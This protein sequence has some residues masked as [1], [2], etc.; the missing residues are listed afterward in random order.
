MA[1]R[2][3]ACRKRHA[4]TR[5]CGGCVTMARGAPGTAAAASPRAAARGALLPVPKVRFPPRSRPAGGGA[6]ARAGGADGGAQTVPHTTLQIKPHTAQ[7]PSGR[8][9]KSSAPWCATLGRSAGGRT[10]PFP[11]RK[12]PWRPRMGCGRRTN[13][14]FHRSFPVAQHERSFHTSKKPKKRVTCVTERKRS[15][16]PCRAR[17]AAMAPFRAASGRAPALS[18]PSCADRPVLGGAGAPRCPGGRPT[19]S[20]A[21]TV[22]HT[23]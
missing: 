18:P 22:S 2:F 11:P 15:R 23:S 16:C 21:Q 5:H 20:G 19:P 9:A 10:A 13:R 12:V 7:A 17:G 1:I 8:G 4:L 14:G 6:S 3:R